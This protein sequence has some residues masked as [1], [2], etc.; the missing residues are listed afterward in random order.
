MPQ[1]PSLAYHHRRGGA[2]TLIELLVVIAI[3]AILIGLLLPAV[4]KVREAAARAKCTN[5]IKQLVLALHSYHDATSHFPSAGTNS[6]PSGN[7][8]YIIFN[9]QGGSAGSWTMQLLPYIE[10]TALY[11]CLNQG[12]YEQTV[13]PTYF[14]PSRRIPGR[15][16]NNFAPVDYYGNAYGASPNY[17][18]GNSFAGIFRGAFN[19]NNPPVTMMSI[20]DGTS[21][22]VGFGEKNLCLA[23]LNTGNDICDNEGQGWGCD[24]GNS[25]NYDNT[26]LPNYCNGANGQP[27]WPDLTTTS[28]C[29]QGNHSFGSSHPVGC[30]FGLMDGSVRLIVYSEGSSANVPGFNYNLIQMLCNIS[31]GG[32]LPSY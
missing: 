25:G 18:G 13:V 28:G 1:S 9:I 5:N 11:N 6:M 14:C 19:G 23:N 32:I 22:T 31:D 2:F 16:Q 7:L 24:F 15:L 3:I 20:T 29:N 21:N 8:P 10:Q 17:N 12:E 30:N 26:S 27:L 4:Q